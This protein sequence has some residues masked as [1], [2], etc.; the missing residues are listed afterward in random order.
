VPL[1]GALGRVVRLSLR[2]VDPRAVPGAQAVDVRGRS[3][4]RVRDEEAEVDGEV[5][6]AFVEHLVMQGAEAD[7]V[8][9]LIRTAGLPP[10][11]VGGLKA[12]RTRV[13]HN[14]VGDV[15]VE[16]SAPAKLLTFRFNGLLL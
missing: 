3:V 11:N 9:H 6:R 12:N 10:L 13:E 4:D 14:R 5:N 8:R 16:G 7:P 1:H 2:R 15:V